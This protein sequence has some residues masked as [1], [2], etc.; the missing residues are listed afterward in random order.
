MADVPDQTIMGRIEQIVQCH[1]QLHHAEVRPQVSA[2]TR[3]VLHEELA[4]LAGDREEARRHYETARDFCN[5]GRDKR[6]A[7]LA[8]RL[9]DRAYLRR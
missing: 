7:N 1:G 8:K 5:D 6:G 3:D 2:G 4:D 9:Q